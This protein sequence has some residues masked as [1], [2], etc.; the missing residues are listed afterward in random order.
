MFMLLL[1]L[2]SQYDVQNDF[3]YYYCLGVVLSLSNRCDA[4]QITMN[5]TE[6][7]L[8]KVCTL[9]GLRGFMSSI[10]SGALW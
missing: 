9:Y 3:N 1:T 6:Q 2:Y 10:Y 7:R 8:P 4:V 5:G